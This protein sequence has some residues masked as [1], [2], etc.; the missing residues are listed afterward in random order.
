MAVCSLGR[1][2]GHEPLPGSGGKRQRGEKHSAHIPIA[3]LLPVFPEAWIK[4]L[5]FWSGKAAWVTTLGSEVCYT[6]GVSAAGVV[7]AGPLPTVP[8]ASQ[9]RKLLP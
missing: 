8:S 3:C 7:V 9:A 1:F 2:A 4:E 5:L 6:S